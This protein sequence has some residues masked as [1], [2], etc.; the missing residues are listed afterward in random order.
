[1]DQLLDTK[2][3]AA[4]L[5]LSQSSLE[6]MR[7]YGNGP[8]FLKLGRAVRYRESDLQAWVSSRS[9]TSTSD[10]AHRASTR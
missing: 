9:V 2:A 8:N 10:D 7:V 5:S 6:K 4:L 1:M 3:A